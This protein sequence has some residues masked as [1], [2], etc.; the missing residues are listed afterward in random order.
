MRL[1]FLHARYSRY[2]SCLVVTLLCLISS[3]CAKMRP[4]EMHIKDIEEQTLGFL[5]PGK[6]TRDEVIRR[7]GPPTVALANQRIYAYRFSL[8]NQLH[9]TPEASGWVGDFDLSA[10]T[11]NLNSQIGP[12][13]RNPCAKYIPFG[14]RE[15]IIIFDKAFLLRRYRLFEWPPTTSK[16]Q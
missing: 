4:G 9:S 16:S 7:L 2:L 5:K 10:A 3:G 8:F 12:S 1:S 14:C 6:T 11:P 13:D 15:A